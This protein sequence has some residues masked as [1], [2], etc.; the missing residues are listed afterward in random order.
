MN[1]MPIDKAIEILTITEKSGSWL[2]EPDGRCA[3]KL[4]IAALKRHQA[5]SKLYPVFN[6]PPLPGETPDD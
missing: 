4:G 2:L 3:L 6:E 5:L 1:K